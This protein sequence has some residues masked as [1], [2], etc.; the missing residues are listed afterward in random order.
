MPRR[1]CS[2]L[3]TLFAVLALLTITASPA[4]GNAIGPHQRSIAQS[5]E[6]PPFAAIPRG[7]R[8]LVARYYDPK[9]G[10]FI[11][12]DPVWDS[13]NVGNQYTF[14]G[15]SPISGRD[16]SG[17]FW[18]LAPLLA[19][20]GTE[21]SAG[22]FFGGLAAAGAGILGGR[23]AYVQSQTA[24]EYD[25]G[26]IGRASAGGAIIGVASG[27]GA[28]YLGLAASGVLSQ[29]GDDLARGEVASVGNYALAG[30]LGP[31]FK[32]GLGGLSGGRGL[33]NASTRFYSQES[34][35]AGLF[36]NLGGPFGQKIAPKSLLRNLVRTEAGRE[37][38]QR[39]RDFAP[40][41]WLNYER[42]PRGIFGMCDEEGITV[43]VRNTQSVRNTAGTLVHE[44]TH[45]GGFG[46]SRRAEVVAEI[47]K[48][49][50]MQNR[51]PSTGEVRAI[52]RRIKKEPAYRDYKWRVHPPDE[53]GF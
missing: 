10:R 33:G 35:T 17:Q 1:W 19:F 30:A 18:F 47:N 43:F 44:V 32:A 7:V 52:I 23:E 41:V 12:R 51:F 29:A 46:G 21:I 38:L 53:G 31:L 6:N 15:N 28:S 11:S 24:T 25:Y 22:M 40:D 8:S 34:P 36:F 37:A 20:G 4:W 2:S 42:A 5:A 50:H 45:L 13:G 48:F 14:C 39:L 26:A 27:I 16:P 49:R 3:S 9:T